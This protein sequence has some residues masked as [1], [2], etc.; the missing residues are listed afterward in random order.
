MKQ[1][2]PILVHVSRNPNNAYCIKV[3][4]DSGWLCYPDRQRAIALLPLARRSERDCR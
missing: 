3:G 2:S 4:L 1:H